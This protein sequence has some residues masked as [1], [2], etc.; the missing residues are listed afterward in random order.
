MQ[1]F[2]RNGFS[3]EVLFDTS[4][5]SQLLV[6]HMVQLDAVAVPHSA[7]KLY[8]DMFHSVNRSNN[9]LKQ[10]QMKNGSFR[11]IAEAGKLDS[12]AGEV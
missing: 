6:K 10:L 2:F 11:Y 3:H 5:Q 8:V 9:T 7:A 1:T 4:T 12:I